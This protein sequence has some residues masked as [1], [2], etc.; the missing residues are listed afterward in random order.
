MK[1]RKEQRVSSWKNKE[2][3]QTLSQ[4]SQKKEKKNTQ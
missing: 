4:T 3:W 2:D 1:G